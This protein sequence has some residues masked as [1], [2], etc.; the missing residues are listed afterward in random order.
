MNKV[1]NGLNLFL[2]N[3]FDDKGEYR[4]DKIF[5]LPSKK[6]CRF[7]EFKNTEYCSYGV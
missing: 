5:A 3:A 2:E 4:T 6:S 7:C 1:N